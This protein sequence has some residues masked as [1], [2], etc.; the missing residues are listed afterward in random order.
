VLT[1]ICQW[2]FGGVIPSR[3][4]PGVLGAW[5]A[6]SAWVQRRW[7]S[8]ADWKPRAKDRLDGGR[9]ALVLGMA[10]VA[11]GCIVLANPSLAA[12]VKPGAPI[13]TG[14]SHRWK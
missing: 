14:V 8:A 5:F 11:I 10:G 12:N 9:A 2:W 13:V 4:W 6:I 1:R 3:W 7:P